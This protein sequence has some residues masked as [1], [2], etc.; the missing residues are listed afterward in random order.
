MSNIYNSSEEN[1]KQ[2]GTTPP[3]LDDIPRIILIC[4]YKRTGKDTL[5]AILSNQVTFSNRFKWR[6]YK[7]PNQINR[8]F[9]SDNETIYYERI[10]FADLLKHEASEIYGIPEIISDSDKDIIKQDNLYQLVIFIL[11]GVH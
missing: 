7:H 8:K 1:N 5:Y 3:L 11:N 4:G 2:M 10:A 6:I 9:Q